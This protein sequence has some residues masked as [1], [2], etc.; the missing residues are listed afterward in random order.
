MSV[1]PL[2]RREYL[3]AGMKLLAVFL[4][5]VVGGLVYGYIILHYRLNNW[6]DFIFFVFIG[7]VLILRQFVVFIK[8]K[9]KCSNLIEYSHFIDNLIFS[10]E[11]AKHK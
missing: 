11:T 9:K 8:K 6:L 7:I 5:F 1:G 2:P 3:L 4:F 10:D